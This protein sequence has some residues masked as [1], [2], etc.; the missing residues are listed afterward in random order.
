MAKLNPHS[1][2]VKVLNA[3]Q[4]S[5]TGQRDDKSQPRQ[6]T[7]QKSASPSGKSGPRPVDD[8]GKAALLALL[9]L[10]SEAREV[11]SEAE[12]V[13]LIANEMRKLTRAR[14]VFVLRDKSGLG[15]TVQGVSSLDS[16]ERNSPLI[17][18]IERMV[19]QL[20]KLDGVDRQREFSLPAYCEPSDEE[21][22][23]YPFRDFV[24]LPFK[25]KD[26]TVFG[27]VLLA[28]EQHWREGD[29]V[30]AKRLAATF[31]HA[32][33]AISGNRRLRSK[34]KTR[35]LLSVAA[36]A[37]ITIA[38]TIPVPISALAPA[39][40]VSARPFVV[41]APID[42][43]IDK[44]FVDPNTKVRQGQPIVKFVDISLRNKLAVAERE[45]I[46][47]NAQLR[48]YTQSA[49]DD[50]EAKREL[51]AAMSKLELKKAEAK[52]ARDLLSKTVIKAK[53]PGFVI[54]NDKSE[55]VGRPVAVGERI[56]EIANSNEVRVKVNL[57]V[58]DAIV[59]SP[60]AHVKV[61]LD[62]DPL[63]PVSATVVRA[64]HEARKTSGDVL[65]Y[66]II[67]RI[68]GDV[69]HLPRLGVR[70]TA[71]I[72]GENAPVFFYLFR[73]PLSALRQKLGL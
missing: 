58:D 44:V 67:A 30:V 64:A 68:T 72:Y 32:W 2:R 16:V 15:L 39:E 48:R 70:G 66:E 7:A 19:K 54:F 57:P 65:A 3:G 55:W 37:C 59:V 56:M 21:T 1:P 11:Q 28:R 62:S 73:R 53:Y 31:S 43:V 50:P 42:G 41:T 47:A 4:K 18:W 6:H 17:R 40:I 25:L 46:V 13:F 63:N 51:R 10:E 38:M 69:K 22:R 33:A 35:L 71:Q 14:Q 9:K 24:W 61:F 36:L 20:K 34:G 8:D 27:G 45:T 26:G 29:L 52:F 23:T 60:N 12:L 49:F 5:A